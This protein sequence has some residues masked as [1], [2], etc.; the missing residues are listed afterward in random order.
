MSVALALAASGCGGESARAGEAEAKA[1]PAP[2]NEYLKVEPVG[3]AS[4]AAGAALPARVAFR[5]Q[6]MTA[7]GSPVT[8]RVVSIEVRPGQAVSA[9]ANLLTLQSADAASAKASL[10]QAR[11]QTALAEDALRRQ[12]EMLAKGV[13]LEVE[14]FQA[15]VAV[16]EARAELQRAQR[17]A[18]L[19][20]RGDSDRFVLRAPAAG[21]VLSV[22][23]NA[24]AVVAA[25]GAALVE[26]GD[27]SRLWVVADVAE[28]EAAAIR[29]GAA[30]R[31]VVPDGD[32]EYPAVVDGIGPQ[33]DGE[34]RRLPVYLTLAG[35]RAPALTPG[36]LVQV[37]LDAAA[38]AAPSVPV[39]AVLI[40]GGSERV[41]Y[42]QRGDG[43]FDARPVRTGVSRGGRVTLLDG[44]K[45]GEK[46]VVEG[47]LLLDSKAEQLL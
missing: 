25:D 34:L 17:A 3:R 12:K 16:R 23:A 39:A 4:A 41:V 8:A 15:D 6:A 2:G 36:A 7:V 11:A 14:R 27:P 26:I 28:S 35:A 24:G 30:A 47:A 46:V 18:D 19:L 32:T 13:G 1:A 22:H 33:V 40:K 10:A 43:G 21:V 9:G 45:P 29:P 37:R 20:G 44:V 5:P 42:V 31:V 38:Q